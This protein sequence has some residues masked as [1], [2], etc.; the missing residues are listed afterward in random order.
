[1]NCDLCPAPAVVEC[2]CL[3]CSDLLWI[4]RLWIDQPTQAELLALAVASGVDPLS[5]REFAAMPA[6]ARRIIEMP[7]KAHANI[8]LDKLTAARAERRRKEARV[9]AEEAA[10][11]RSRQ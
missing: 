6:C 7:S 10:L 5:R 3:A 1:M 11:E 2:L 9:V 8:F 4:A